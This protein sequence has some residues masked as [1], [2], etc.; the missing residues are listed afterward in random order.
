MGSDSNGYLRVA[1]GFRVVHWELASGVC[2]FGLV[3]L[4]VCTCIF[5]ALIAEAT[6]AVLE[7]ELNRP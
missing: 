7:P 1:G 5:S 4:L 6:N 2:F 3:L